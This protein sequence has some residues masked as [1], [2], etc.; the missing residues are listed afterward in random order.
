MTDV[1]TIKLNTKEE[2]I[3]A[4]AANR[5]EPKFDFYLIILNDGK[6]VSR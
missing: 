3:K 1:D 4:F 5:D 6:H 2:M